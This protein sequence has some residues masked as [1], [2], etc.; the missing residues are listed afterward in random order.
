MF[1]CW[2]RPDP[3]R[4][5]DSCTGCNNHIPSTLTANTARVQLIGAWHAYR[6]VFNDGW[7]A[8]AR[9]RVR[10]GGTSKRSGK[11][12]FSDGRRS[13][14][15]PNR[16]RFSVTRPS[17]G[18][19]NRSQGSKHERGITDTFGYCLS[20]NLGR[21]PPRRVLTNANYLATSLKTGMQNAWATRCETKHCEESMTC[22]PGTRTR[23][24]IGARRRWKASTPIRS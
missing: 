15:V 16:L 24:S 12:V 3:S 9:S 19:R 7:F 21:S 20:P 17:Y 23:Y 6:L 13:P 18:F 4:Y 1:I 10:T 14:P 8:R 5:R 2:W 22:A 11:G